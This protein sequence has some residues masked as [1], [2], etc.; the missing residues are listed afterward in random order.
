MTEIE[1]IQEGARVAGGPE[2][3]PCEV[4]R[5]DHSVETVPPLTDRPCVRLWVRREDTNEEGFMTFGPRGMVE[6]L[7]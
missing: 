5:I 4:L 1:N 6:V 7:A 2:R 3:V